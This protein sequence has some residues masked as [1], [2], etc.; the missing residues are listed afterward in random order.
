MS[1]EIWISTPGLDCRS[2]PEGPII[3]RKTSAQQQVAPISRGQPY[4]GIKLSGAMPF[5]ENKNSANYLI[6]FRRIILLQQG[7]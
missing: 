4:Y 2:K 6:W 3:I 5:Q 7:K 1:D